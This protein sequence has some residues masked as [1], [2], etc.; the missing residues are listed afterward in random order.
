MMPNLLMEPDSSGIKSMSEIATPLQSA[1]ALEELNQK[2]TLL[3]VGGDEEPAHTQGE[4]S[5]GWGNLAHPQ[6]SSLVLPTHRH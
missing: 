3:A 6:R 4:G 1:S 5:R 2:R